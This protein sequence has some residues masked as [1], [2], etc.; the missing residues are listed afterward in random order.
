MVDTKTKHEVLD[1]PLDPLNGHR[2]E[3]FERVKELIAQ[4]VDGET[5]YCKAVNEKL[6]ELGK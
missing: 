5:A 4:G 2:S 6:R 1:D 3:V